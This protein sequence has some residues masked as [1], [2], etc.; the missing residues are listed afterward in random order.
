MTKLNIGDRVV[1]TSGYPFPGTYRGSVETSRGEERV[2]VEHDDGWLHIFNPSQIQA[3]VPRRSGN[4]E[5]RLFRGEA[6][7]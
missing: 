7:A 1:K 3:A 5:P 4:D 2:I 6:L